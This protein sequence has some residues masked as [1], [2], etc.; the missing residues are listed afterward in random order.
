MI[1]RVVDVPTYGYYA[2]RFDAGDKERKDM[3]PRS[4]GW[5]DY[6]KFIRKER[7][8]S[9]RVMRRIDDDLDRTL[10]LRIS[11]TDPGMNPE[12]TEQDSSIVIIFGTTIASYN[13][14]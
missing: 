8:V 12:M 11:K 7:S 2:P 6:V 5:R 4:I 3:V 14:S 1:A 13:A 10:P 9:R